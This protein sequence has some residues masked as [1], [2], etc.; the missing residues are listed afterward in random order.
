MFVCKY[1]HSVV[2]PLIFASYYS[3]VLNNLKLNE[4]KVNQTI[5]LLTIQQ[6]AD[7]IGLQHNQIWTL[8][9]A[10][11]FSNPHK[12]KSEKLAD[13]DLYDIST[14]DRPVYRFAKKKQEIEAEKVV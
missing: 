8:I 5:K 3:T 14:N 9:Q 2:C 11:K 4:M 12:G 7:E 13:Y 6:L 1:L 10:G